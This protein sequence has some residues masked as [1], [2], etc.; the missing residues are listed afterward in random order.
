MLLLLA[1]LAFS[2]VAA[3]D[4]PL[5]RPRPSIPEDT[6]II[7]IETP[8]GPPTECDGRLSGLAVFEPK[9]SI[10]G[11]GECGA[12]DLVLL[13]AILL[14]NGRRAEVKP[15]AMLACEMAESLAGWVRDEVAPNVGARGGGLLAIQQDGAYECRNRNRAARGKVSEHARGKAI[16][17]RGFVLADKSVITLTDVYASKE[18]RTTFHNSACRRFTTVLGPGEPYHDDH[19]HLDVI[20]RPR[21]YRMCAWAVREAPPVVAKGAPENEQPEAEKS[22]SDQSES[23]GGHD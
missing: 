19:I 21:A 16:D 17:L 20:Q 14:A 13:S 1:A 18:L 5:P 6:G 11:P 22:E 4:V 2:S 9:P 10:A 23:S 15:A 12:D 7:L 3:G 8:H